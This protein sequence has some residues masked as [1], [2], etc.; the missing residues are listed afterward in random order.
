MIPAK[1]FAPAERQVL[2]PLCLL[3]LVRLCKKGESS[4]A[5]EIKMWF[6]LPMLRHHQSRGTRWFALALQGFRQYHRRLPR[7]GH[8]ARCCVDGP[9]TAVTCH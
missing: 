6:N 3:A 2:G 8:H 1:G 5:G 9:P 4:T 7:G